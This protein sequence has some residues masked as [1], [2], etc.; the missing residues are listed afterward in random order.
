M[1][2]RLAFPHH[3]GQTEYSARAPAH[4]GHYQLP[5]TLS[6]QLSSHGGVV[7][8]VRAVPSPADDELVVLLEDWRISLRAR[9]LSPNT[10]ESYLSSVQA[11]IWFAEAMRRANPSSGAL[12]RPHGYYPRPR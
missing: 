10:I 2:V 11:Y 12:R 3:T 5:I 9:G 7:E 4:T 1:L 8:K 6:I